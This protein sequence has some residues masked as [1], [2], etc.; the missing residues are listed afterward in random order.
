MKGHL[1]FMVACLIGCTTR[2]MEGLGVYGLG[3][4]A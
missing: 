4:R 3:F 2:L 1:P